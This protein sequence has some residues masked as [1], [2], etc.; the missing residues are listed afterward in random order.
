MPTK[1]SDRC[2]GK[3]S[4][5]LDGHTECAPAKCLQ[6]AAIGRIEHNK[7]LGTMERREIFI[8]NLQWRLLSYG[9]RGDF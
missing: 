1:R 8:L 3:L 6:L 5:F 7:N 2:S 4:S 9:Y